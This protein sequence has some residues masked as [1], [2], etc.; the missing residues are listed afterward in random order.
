[1][2]ISRVNSGFKFFLYCL[3]MWL[4]ILILQCKSSFSGV[5]S[6]LQAVCSGLEKGPFHS[7]NILIYSLTNSGFCC[8]GLHILGC[9][10]IVNI[11]VLQ[12]LWL[13]E[14]T[15]W[16]KPTIN[17]TRINPSLPPV[18]QESTVLCRWLKYGHHLLLFVA[19]KYAWE[20]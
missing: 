18:V 1:M 19:Y 11:T 3:Q 5:C 8:T 2:T 15:H 14:F 12:G 10:S 16:K 13:V 7:Q 4:D 6:S 9:F 17:Y 20:R